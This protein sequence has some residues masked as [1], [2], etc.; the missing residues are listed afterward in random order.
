MYMYNVHVY[1]T[2]AA[3]KLSTISNGSGGSHL[4]ASRLFH[5][6]SGY[7]SEPANYKHSYVWGIHV[8]CKQM[9]GMLAM[10]GPDK[11]AIPGQWLFQAS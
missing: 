1:L 2:P 11:P 8:L 5:T 6:C 3:G 10:V 9:L 7:M 4:S